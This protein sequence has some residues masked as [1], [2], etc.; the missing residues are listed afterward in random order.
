MESPIMRK[1]MLA[2]V[3]AVVV[4][5]GALEVSRG[6]FINNSVQVPVERVVANVEAWIKDKPQDAQAYYVLGRIHAMA[7]AY[8]ADLNL[9][10]ATPAGGARG[11]GA[12][13]GGRGAAGA[14]PFAGQLPGFA[15]YD[16]VEVRRDEQ[17]KKVTAEDAKHLEES[18]KNYTKAVELDK[19][20]AL[21][22]L[23]LGWILQETGKVAASLPVGFGGAAE[24]KVTAEEKAAYE[25][26]IKQLGDA[27]AKTRDD[28][29]AV[30]RGAM[31]K[32]LAQLKAVKGDDPEVTA[33]VEGLLRGYWEMQA[34]E[35]YRKAYA[36]R[37]DQDL[38]RPGGLQSGD[39]QLA[40]EAGEAILDV[41][42]AQPQA[43][44]ENEARDVAANVKTLRGKPM[45]VTPVIFAMPE[46]G[47]AQHV[48]DLVDSSK[49]VTFDLA[50]DQ[51]A[52]TWP[53][54]KDGTALLVWDP[55]H[56]A[57][58]TNG[59]Q[60]FGSRTW[61]IFFRDGYEALSVL[62][63]NRDGRLTGAELQG[64]AVWIDR[65]GDGVSQAGEVLTLEQA[66]IESIGVRATVDGDGTLTNATGVRFVDGRTVRTFD[67]VTSPVQTDATAGR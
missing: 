57:A 12:G 66:G 42:K 51:V 22:E 33:R 24:V 1:W 8:G 60:L 43:A 30:L 48:G 6:M 61:W 46:M 49:R 19:Q 50:G 35:H 67:W 27:D 26:S 14:D 20:N 28:A 21:Y 3:A 5:G 23:G 2:A 13:D 52:R 45:A 63:D 11:S 4:L 29:S 54:L 62:D 47:P 36:L 34:L 64:I 41:L 10:R 56:T 25:G 37:V 17:K 7:W 44:K 38:K 55:A 53:W 59:R 39:T 16:S 15:P 65:N 58:I 18:I 9:W 40:A 31:P 32:P